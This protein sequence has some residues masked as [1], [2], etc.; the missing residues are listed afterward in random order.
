MTL[1][2]HV[3]DT[4]KEWQV[5]M[6]SLDSNIRLYYPKASLCRYLSLSMEI[7]NKELSEYMEQYFDSHAKYL[8]RVT[9]HAEHDRFCVMVGK[10]GCDYIEKKVPEPE[11]LTKLLKVLKNQKM[12]NIIQ[13]FEEYARMHGTD[14][15]IRNEEGGLETVL[16]FEDEKVEPYVYCIDANEFGITYHRFTKDE[17][18]D[19]Y[20]TF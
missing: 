8:G 2:K 20:F 6:G 18:M 3:I 10:E 14:I 13:F 5:K 16:Y 17:Y 15:C 4:M 7:D 1:E 12:Q 19:L 9:V 11:F